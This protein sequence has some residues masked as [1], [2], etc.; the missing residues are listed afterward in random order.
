MTRRL[1]VIGQGV[2]SDFYPRF[3]VDLG[4]QPV[5]VGGAG[6][7]P[8]NDTG[9]PGLASDPTRPDPDLGAQFSY[10]IPHPTALRPDPIL[11]SAEA[12]CWALS[13]LRD[14]STYSRGN[15]CLASPTWS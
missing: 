14:T 15:A 13:Y 7:S 6:C 11:E 1:S 5:G 2:G 4:G 8:G 10:L 9:F 12:P 3:G